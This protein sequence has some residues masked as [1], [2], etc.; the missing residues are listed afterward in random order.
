[1]RKEFTY[2]G[3]PVTYIVN[4][5]VR[6]ED[7]LRN[8]NVTYDVIP[9]FIKG[10]R[11]L[12]Y[13]GKFAIVRTAN[14][15]EHEVEVIYAFTEMP[16]DYNLLALIEE[17]DSQAAGEEPREKCSVFRRLYKIVCTPAEKDYR[18]RALVEDDPFNLFAGEID[19]DY[20]D[21]FWI[22]MLFG[23]QDYG[24]PLGR[25]KEIPMNDDDKEL[26]D[27]LIEKC[28]KAISNREK[29]YIDMLNR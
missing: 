5:G 10:L 16:E 11:V 12:K 17:V 22:D 8:N 9:I 3:L 1:M 18:N 25:I 29:E 24:Y 14:I 4:D 13:N 27:E 26:F 20:D 15:P 21:Q 28:N 23:F 7:V 2:L 6:Y 19:G